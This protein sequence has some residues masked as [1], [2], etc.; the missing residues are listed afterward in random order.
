VVVVVPPG[1]EARFR[2]WQKEY[3][4]GKIQA[5][6]PGGADRQASVAQ[7]LAR[8]EPHYPVV[9]VHDGARPLASP[10]LLDRA[11]A[12]AATY[13]SAVAAIPVIETLKRAPDGQHVLQTVDRT[14]LWAVQTPQAFQRELLCRAHAQAAQEGFRGTDEASLVEHCGH[15]VRL[16]PGERTNLK[17]TLPEDFIVAEALLQAR[18]GPAPPARVGLGYDIHGLVP[19]RPLWLGGV[20]IPFPLGLAGHSDA[21]ALLH[22]IADAILG[23]L[24]AGDI[25]EHFPDTDPQYQ[26]ASSLELLRQVAGIMRQHGYTVGNVDAVIVAEAPR[27][28][29]YRAAMQQQ[30]AS[31][32]S[33]DPRQI[34]LKA[35]TH[36]GLGTLGAGGG[37]AAQAIVNLY[38]V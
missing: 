29:P 30:I 3:G 10:E 7:G 23:A 33:C 26:N 31:A 12:A 5:V 17:I 1:K 19:D 37:I 4:L 6:V 18:R 20:R 9:L 2:D 22:A 38:R 14:G 21:D 35:T 16:I 13:G 8:V 24:N 36:E 28:A 15:S 11:A 34:S 32:L 27:L 25:G